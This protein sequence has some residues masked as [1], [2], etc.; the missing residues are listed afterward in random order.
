MSQKKIKKLKK[1][2]SPIVEELI[3]LP[4][5]KVFLK[6]FGWMLVVIL[7]GV[8]AVFANGIKGDF[9]SD[10]YATVPQN[11]KVT[12]FGASVL[13][14][15]NPFNSMNVANFVVANIFGVASPIPYH[16]LSLVTYL[17]SIFLACWFIYLIT[18]NERL[19]LLSILIFA[20][21]PIHVEAVS[22]NAGKIYLIISNY[23]LMA[24][25]AFIYFLHTNKNKYGVIMLVT[26][27]LA[28]L[29][30]RPRPFAVFLIVPGLLGLY[31]KDLVIRFLKKSLKWIVPSAIVFLIIAFPYVESRVNIV[32]S[33]INESGSIFYSP[34]FQYPI[35]VAKYLQLMM[36]PTDLTL[37]HTMFPLPGWLNWMI[38]LL[39][40]ILVINFWFKNKVWF[41]SLFFIF[42]ATLP[43][44]APVKVSWL[45]A[46]RYA[47]LGTLG[48]AMF[49]G[50][51]FMKLSQKLKLI[52]AVLLIS[53]ISV[54]IV[55]IYLRNNDWSTNHLLWVNTCQVSPNSHNAWNNIGDDYDKL[56]DYANSVKGFTQSTIVKPNYADAYHNRANIFFKLGKLDLA[57]ESYDMA[58]HFNSGLFQTY[59][60]LVQIDLNEKKYDLALQHINKS[61][62][63]EPNNPQNLYILAVVY[64]QT[65][66]IEEAK[67]VL[68]TILSKFPNYALAKSALLELDGVRVGSS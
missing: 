7:L 20:F 57:R 29:T 56:K 11:P 5:F 23:V 39:Y 42:A 22:W 47:Y 32:N 64:A 61:I 54:Y 48:F 60:S 35:S 58:I 33:G 24:L 66:K 52:P 25:I 31:P 19:T 63:F 30:D 59:L 53:L 4:N 16:V 6:K 13:T 12:D 18:G 44:M 51:I 14:P 26:F 45:V 40:I 1:I 65:G 62:E 28:F 21:M 38:L 3:V 15:G 55:R 10:D 34:F 67:N 36:V 8:T 46:E 50:L 17:L 68:K 27:F 37:Y 9:V 2:V 49:L 41:F 43:S